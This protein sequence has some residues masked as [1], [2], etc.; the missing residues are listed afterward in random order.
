MLFL[1]ITGSAIYIALWILVGVL[2]GI[3]Y[4]LERWL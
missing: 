3:N 4:Y 2:K 1:F